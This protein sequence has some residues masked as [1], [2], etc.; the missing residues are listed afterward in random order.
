MRYIGGNRKPKATNTINALC[1]RYT[2][3]NNNILS[4]CIYVYN[5]YT[6]EDVFSVVYA[7]KVDVLIAELTNYKR[8]KSAC[9]MYLLSYLMIA[10]GS[11][12]G[13]VFFS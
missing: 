6:N 10:D 7:H 8:C 12:L 9:F 13:C 2:K 5:I 4:S 11:H 1:I 3:N